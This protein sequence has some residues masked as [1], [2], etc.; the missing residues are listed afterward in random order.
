MNGLYLRVNTSYLELMEQVCQ[1]LI[2]HEK[3]VIYLIRIICL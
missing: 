3:N 2:K 1:S